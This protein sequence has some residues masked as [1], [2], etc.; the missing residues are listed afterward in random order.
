MDWKSWHPKKQPLT[1]EWDAILIGS[2]LGALMCAAKL[3]KAGR[4][5]LVLE[6]HYV[7][8]GYAH[9]FQ[10][11]HK[12]AKY[13]FDVA[14]HQ[15]GSLKNGQFMR[16]AFEETGVL[17][18]LDLV[19]MNTVYRSVFPDFDITVPQDLE[20]YRALL[21]EKFPEES[22]GIDRYFGIMTAIPEEISRMGM[23]GLETT[24]DPA[25]VAP[26]AMRLMTSSLADVFDETIENPQLRAIL[27]QL[28]AYLGLPPKE[29]SAII[30]AQMWCSF[31]LGGCFYI[32][33]GG[34]ALSNAFCE[35]IEEAGGAIKL[36]TMVEKILVDDAGRACGVRTAA[37]EEF[38][39]PVVV[40]NA[41]APMTFNELLDPGVVPQELLDQVNN[42][43]IS[44]SIIEAYIGI[45]GDAAELGLA[46]HELFI[47]V[48]TDYEAE[49]EAVQRDDIE[50]QGVLL[51]NH[52]SVNADACPPGKSVI[53]AAILA[54]G[55]YWIGLSEEEYAAKKARVTEFLLDKVAEFIPDIRDRIEVI[56]VG[57]PKTM[58]EYSLNPEGAVYGYANLPSTHTIFRPQQ[59]TPIPGL[60]LAGAWTFPG[61][62]FGGAMT[63]GYLAAQLILADARG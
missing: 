36:R 5:C 37:G 31:H 42:L 22:E 38:T 56:E 41:S 19:E 58:Y 8:G 40:S 23:P 3:A 27:A 55:K 51:A 1:R 9:H 26:T 20:S 30:W 21:K 13:L 53:E 61:P 39:A 17:D 59:R 14:L 54:M 10:R 15:T 63:S 34:Q 7:A 45:D 11:K 49:W 57:T 18:K 4:R 25:E 6:Q 62:G 28:W 52:S 2:G 43:P 35:V 16:K 46:E 33:G 47:N 24:G 32:R 48:G 50:H 60:Y 29:C 12:G 44:T